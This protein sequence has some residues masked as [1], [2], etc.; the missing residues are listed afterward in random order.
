MVHTSLMVSLW[1]VWIFAVMA[2]RVVDMLA[3]Q[4]LREPKPSFQRTAE[5]VSN[6]P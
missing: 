6:L 2:M 3:M 4:P 5:K 1:P